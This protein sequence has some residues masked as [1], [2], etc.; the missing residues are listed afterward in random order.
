MYGATFADN[1]SSIRIAMKDA[2]MVEAYLED[3]GL[4]PAYRQRLS[5]AIRKA[6]SYGY[7]TVPIDVRDWPLEDSL[8]LPAYNH[9]FGSR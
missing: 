7:D 3:T 6:V 2:T 8:W 4:H 1:E 5:R 9:K